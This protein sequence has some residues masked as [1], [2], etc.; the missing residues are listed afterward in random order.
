MT[1]S[2]PFVIATCRN[3]PAGTSMPRSVRRTAAVPV[4]IASSTL[5]PPTVM[6]G[7]AKMLG[8]A[9]VPPRSPENVAATPAGV[10]SSAPV[11]WCAAVMFTN[12]PSCSVRSVTASATSPLG[13]RLIRMP[14]APSDCPATVIDRA[15]HLDLESRLH[16]HRAP[17]RRPGPRRSAPELIC[18]VDDAGDLEPGIGDV[19]RRS[20]PNPPCRSAVR[21][22]VPAISVTRDQRRARG[23]EA[24]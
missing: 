3:G 22:K 2:T 5:P 7:R 18:T 15:G 4:L 6:P 17:C 23:A 10:T 11:Q 13:V 12:V 9:T 19:E 20:R 1:A 16:G 14:A 24:R 21:R 8:R